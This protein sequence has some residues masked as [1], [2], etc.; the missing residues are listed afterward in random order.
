MADKKCTA[1]QLKQMFLDDGRTDV[2]VVKADPIEEAI[3]NYWG[4]RCPDY[5]AD[6]VVCQAWKEFDAIEYVHKPMSKDELAKVKQ[7]KPRY[8]RHTG[9]EL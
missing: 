3:E 2:S 4:E 9:E 7:P 8:M 6:C 5:D 1:E